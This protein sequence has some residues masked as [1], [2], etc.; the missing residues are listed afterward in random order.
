MAPKNL[1]VFLED[2]E[3]AFAFRTS[4]LK[5]RSTSMAVA[6]IFTTYLKISLTENQVRFH[7]ENDCCSDI[8]QLFIREPVGCVSM[9]RNET[10]LPTYP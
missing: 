6:H 3:M 1:S 5:L 8:G 2:T 7:W 10:S 9:N 4:W